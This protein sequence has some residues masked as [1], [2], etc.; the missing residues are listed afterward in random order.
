MGPG[1]R[2]PFIQGTTLATFSAKGQRANTPSLACHGVCATAPQ[3][4][5]RGEHS[6]RWPVKQRGS[7]LFQENSSQGTDI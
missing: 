4:G 7:P 6:C 1:M 2:L 3:H 5:L